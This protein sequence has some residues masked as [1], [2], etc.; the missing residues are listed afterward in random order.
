M[1]DI[2]IHGFRLIDRSTLVGEVD[3]QSMVNPL[4]IQAR[5]AAASWQLHGTFYSYIGNPNRAAPSN[6]MD[7]VIL[8]D[9]D[10]A[11][12]L[13]YHDVDPFGK[14]YAR[15]FAKPVLDHGGLVLAGGTIGVSVSSVVSHE[16]LEAMAD[17]Y[18]NQWVTLP[19]G[20]TMVARE[21]CDPVQGFNYLVNGVLISNW[22][23]PNWFTD[24]APGPYDY[25]NVCKKPFEV[26]KGGYRII[27]DVKGFRAIDQDSSPAWRRQALR[28]HPASRTFKRVVLP[29]GQTAESR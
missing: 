11:D 6:E 15:V 10:Q 3:L 17:Q 27:A 24:K 28:G 21:L 23:T 9:A 14:P 26:A 7:I 4:R 5:L 1:T 19:D 25:M 12:A 18:C 13:G 8:D 29:D 20:Q 22:V 16:L 2:N